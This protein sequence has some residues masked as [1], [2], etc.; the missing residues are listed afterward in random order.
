MVNLVVTVYL[1]IF[2]YII[3]SHLTLLNGFYL[4]RV[5]PSRGSRFL[6]RDEADYFLLGRWVSAE[7]AADLA[8]LLDLGSRRTFEAAD[9]AFALVTSLLA[10]IITSF[11]V[12]G[13]VKL[14][15]NRV[16]T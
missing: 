3:A 9:A 12:S 10:I 1:S 16:A 7:A 11:R 5:C 14:S 2:V 15:G 13:W 6:P 8:A 4:H